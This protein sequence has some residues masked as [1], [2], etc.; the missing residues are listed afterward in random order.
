MNVQLRNSNGYPSTLAVRIPPRFYRGRRGIGDSAI[1]PTT[2]WMPGTGPGSGWLSTP[3]NP[4]TASGGPAVYQAPTLAP[5]PSCTQ[6]TRPGGAAFSDACIAQ[7]LATQ[8]ANMQLLNDANFKVDYTNCVNGGNAPADCASRTYGLTPTGGYTSDAHPQGVQTYLNAQGQQV[9]V[10]GQ[11]IDPMTGEPPVAPSS[12]P[13]PTP[14]PK[15]ASGGETSGGTGGSGSSSVVPGIPDALVYW[16][17][18][19]AALGV[20]ISVVK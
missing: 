14:T 15:T 6:D 5:A 20:F 19:L 1:N 12:T 2:I 4:A 10:T 8:Q 3:G 17:V 18:G 11:M 16:S 9:T 13:T 7:L